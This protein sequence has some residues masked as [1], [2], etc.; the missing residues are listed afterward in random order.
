LTN[1]NKGEIIPTSIQQTKEWKM[2][3]QQVVVR[4]GFYGFSAENY[5]PL[6]D[7]ADRYLRVSTSKRSNGSVSTVATVIKREG[8]FDTYIVFQDFSKTIASNKFARVTEKVIK[9]QQEAALAGIAAVAQEAVV[10][11]Q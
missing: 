5:V 9:A 2:V 1:R 10:Q 3:A 7:I 4:K 8:G 11:Y 6:P